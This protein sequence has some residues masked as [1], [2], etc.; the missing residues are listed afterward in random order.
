MGIWQAV[1]HVL[2]NFSQSWLIWVF[3]A[4]LLSAITVGLVNFFED[5][6]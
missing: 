1:W 4:G 3:G 5:R 6:D 2:S